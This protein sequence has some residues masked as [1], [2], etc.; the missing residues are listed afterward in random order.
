MAITGLPLFSTIVYFLLI[1]PVLF[2]LVRHGKRGILGWLPLVSFCLIR[3]IGGI[4]KLVV[5]GRNGNVRAE[6]ILIVES[7]G[8][9]PLFLGTLGVI[10]E[11]RMARNQL[12]SKERKVLEWAFIAVYHSI[13]T[14]ALIIII[15]GIVNDLDNNQRPQD[16]TL[17]KVGISITWVLWAIQTVYAAAAFVRRSSRGGGHDGVR[18]TERFRLGRVLVI[19]G[20]LALPFLAIR[21]IFGTLAFNLDSDSFAN[22]VGWQAGL[23]VVPEIML[24]GILTFAG[25][26]TRRIWKTPDV[27]RTL[28]SA[29]PASTTGGKYYGD[30]SPAMQTTSASTAGLGVAGKKPGKGKAWYG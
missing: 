9:A 30:A 14:A 13:V 4:M 8:I 7:I 27:D 15:I 12:Y 18:A 20:N 17:L 28:A 25:L 16:S 2:N 6:G 29:S 19:A 3:I 21:L 1:G 23:Q 22:A 5:Q 10:H 11:G 24:V 26:Y